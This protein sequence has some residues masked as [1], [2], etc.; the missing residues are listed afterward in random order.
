MEEVLEDSVLEERLRAHSANFTSM[1][2]LIPSKFR[3][4][5]KTGIQGS[6]SQG[7]KYWINKVKTKTPKQSVKDTTKKAK[8]LK[9]DQD[10][11]AEFQVKPV[12]S[13]VPEEEECS[14][15]EGNSKRDIPPSRG[16][17]LVNGFSVE[18]VRST[19]LNDLQKRLKVE[20]QRKRNLS[21]R[22]EK[23]VEE[24]RQK[25]LE[26]RQRKKELQ[27]KNRTKKNGN[28]QRGITSLPKRPSIKDETGKIVFSKFD[29]STSS[30]PEVK[31]ENTPKKRDFR[32]LLAK[33]EAAQ[34]KLEE[35]KK[36][37]EKRGE[38]LEKKLKWQRALDMARGTKLKDDPKLLKRTINSLEKKKHKSSVEWEERKTLEKQAAEKRQERRK[39]NIQER[40]DKI[41]AKK[42]KKRGK[43]SRNPGF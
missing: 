15:E 13:K 9:L 42:M 5:T 38:E 41:K 21:D 2:E 17:Q 22:N 33:A 1:L 19:N 39:K 37:D 16:D 18:Q 3:E 12:E 34:K 14:E 23:T 10:S 8:K 40:I 20:L 29:F 11:T 6:E 25:R 30:C 31:V 32:K 28:Q 35:L 27:N 43:K 4:E 36:Q 24:K 7:S 26:K